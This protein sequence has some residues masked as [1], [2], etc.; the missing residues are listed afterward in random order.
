MQ[1]IKRNIMK[2]GG[3]TI[4]LLVIV[5]SYVVFGVL[6]PSI[7]KAK[8]SEMEH[9]L[10]D[11]GYSNIKLK[12]VSGIYSEAYFSTNKGDVTIRFSNN[13]LFQLVY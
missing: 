11:K 8:K 13:G 2:K 5:T 9:Y 3:I 10:T 6:K 7:I 12:D 1:F 4:L